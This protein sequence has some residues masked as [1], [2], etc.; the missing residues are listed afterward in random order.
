[1]IT[2]EITSFL[3]IVSFRRRKIMTVCCIHTAETSRKDTEQKRKPA[4]SRLNCLNPKPSTCIRHLLR[5]GRASEQSQPWTVGLSFSLMKISIFLVYEDF[6]NKL[7]PAV[8][9]KHTTEVETTCYPSRH[10]SFRYQLSQIAIPSTPAQI[11][12]YSPPALSK[13][14]L[15]DGKCGELNGQVGPD[16][17][18]LGLLRKLVVITAKSLFIILEKSLWIEKSCVNVKRQT[19]HSSSQK[20]KE[21]SP[22]TLVN[23]TR[24]SSP[25]CIN[26]HK[27]QC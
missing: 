13:L 14:M 25:A 27:R 17:S 23:K 22:G 8:I 6:F 16:G 18:Y 24:L 3:R 21:K 10:E 5:Q 26:L 2:K 20:G 19:L 9:F 11:F 1:M 12:A 7:V 4:R 15:R